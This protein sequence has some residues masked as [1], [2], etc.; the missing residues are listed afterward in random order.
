MRFSIAPQGAANLGKN[1]FELVPTR[2]KTD[3]TSTVESEAPES[4]CST[5]VQIFFPF[6]LAGFG[7][8]MAGVVLDVVVNWDVFVNVEEIFILVPALLGLK[9]NLEM[10]LASRLSTQASLGNLD[11]CAAATP[12]VVGNLALIQCQSTV[13]GFLASV[14]AA[15]L[16][17]AA[18]RT[19]SF[20]HMVLLCASSIA[21]ASIASLVLGLLMI[22]VVAASRKCGCNPDNIAAP[23]AASLGDLTTLVLLASIANTTWYHRSGWMDEIIILVYCGI[24]A[25]VCAFIASKNEDTKKVLQSG[26]TPVLA[27]MCISSGG[28]LI[29]DHAIERFPRMA[30][31]QPVI[32]GAGSNLAA[33]QASRISTHLHN[34]QTEIGNFV[35]DKDSDRSLW[36]W[37][38]CCSQSIHSRTASVLMMLVVP[39]QIVFLLSIYASAPDENITF[40]FTCLYLTATL[41]QEWILLFSCVHLVHWQ[42][43]RGIDPDS[44]AVPYLAALGDFCGS[45]LLLGTFALLAFLDKEEGIEDP[46]VKALNVTMVH[47]ISHVTA[48]FGRFHHLHQGLHVWRR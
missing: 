35:E 13:V 11:S 2:E 46:E 44:A 9:G 24:I 40:Q 45:A 38:V 32:N 7:M 16:N 21:T 25:P 28:G 23:V 36:P 41:I 29:L 14:V 33:V 19:F 17:Y 12:L 43:K 3:D 26:W 48:K 20:E 1:Q 18:T 10:T 6:I 22:G 34:G 30:A 42:W 39:G 5:A 31:F 27:S 4:Q 47:N 8:V 15:G 37:T